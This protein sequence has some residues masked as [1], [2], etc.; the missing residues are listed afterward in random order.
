MTAS[1][2]RDE[3]VKLLTSAQ[4]RLFSYLTM[5]LGDVHEA[6]NV[7]QET[8]VTLWT[9]AD[10]FALGTN[11]FAWAREV[12]Y[13]KALAFTRDRRRDKLILDQEFV[14]QIVE[15]P[16]S[17]EMDQRRATLRHCL[18]ELSEKQLNLLRQ[19]YGNGTSIAAIARDE[20][21]TVAAVKMVLRRLR[22]ALMG[23][24]ERR[25]ALLR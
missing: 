4:P 13:F 15:E 21:K 5:V 14:E 22:M 25:L 1:Q 20:H 17:A 8:N 2:S 6:N 24:I 18:S 19:R 9:K 7:L 16:T 12:A 23:C 10:E 11:F 3:F